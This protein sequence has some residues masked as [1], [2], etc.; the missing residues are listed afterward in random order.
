MCEVSTYK[1][2]IQEIGRRRHHLASR[3]KPWEIAMNLHYI[4]SDLR[5]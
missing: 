4:S 3:E 2:G 1:K 5:A